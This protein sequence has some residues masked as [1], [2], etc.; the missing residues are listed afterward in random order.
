MALNATLKGTKYMH[1]MS[2]NAP[3]VC[4][5]VTFS[6]IYF[7]NIFLLP[8]EISLPFKP[9]HPAPGDFILLSVPMNFPLLG[10]WCK[11]FVPVCL[12]H[13]NSMLSR[14]LCAV[15]S[16]MG[17]CWCQGEGPALRGFAFAYVGT[18]STTSVRLVL[19]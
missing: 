1:L 11:V 19:N 13:L 10:P 12:G 3:S 8:S 2:P 17:I 9:L 7:Q 6:P 16:V 15:A 14:F 4:F 5:H 18:S